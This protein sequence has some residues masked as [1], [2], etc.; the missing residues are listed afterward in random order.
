M[1]EVRIDKQQI[2]QNLVATQTALL[3][4]RKRF[5]DHLPETILKEAA[6]EIRDAAKKKFR[7]F[8][9][10]MTL[11]IHVTAT[12]ISVITK[13]IPDSFFAD[14]AVDDAAYEAELIRVFEAGDETLH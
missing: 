2:L 4:A 5:L 8:L 1:K 12:L 7:E 10:K 11:D 14:I 6:G 9:D 3:S 13:V